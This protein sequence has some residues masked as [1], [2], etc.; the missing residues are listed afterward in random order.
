MPQLLILRHAKS[1]WGVGGQSDF[2][3][4]LAERGLYDAPRMG[5]WLKSQD[6]VP[7][8]I[9]S[10]SAVRTMQTTDLVAAEMG[11]SDADIEFRPDF[12]ET[13]PGYLIQVLSQ[14]PRRLHRIMIVGHNPT[15]EELVTLLNENPVPI[16]KDG[17]LMGTATVAVMEVPDW[18]ELEPRSA[19]LRLLVRP[20]HLPE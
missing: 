2:E 13:T 8:K 16:P 17:K 11:I 15:L 3:R 12:Y 5:A 4:P 14:F 7:D 9:L 19:Q 1:D 10:S 6:L 18:A 20:K